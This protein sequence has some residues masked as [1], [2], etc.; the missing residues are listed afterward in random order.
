MDFSTE[1]LRSALAVDPA[2]TRVGM[3]LTALVP[4]ALGL[5]L[6]FWL[7]T[8]PT[9]SL[10]SKLRWAAFAPLVFGIVYGGMLA[11]RSMNGAYREYHLIGRNMVALHWAS[12]VVPVLCTIVILVMVVMGSN[13]RRHD[14]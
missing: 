3:V 11:L 10:F 13:R 8:R 7:S 14:F 6:W 4:G 9:G 1:L 12:F 2:P 5:I